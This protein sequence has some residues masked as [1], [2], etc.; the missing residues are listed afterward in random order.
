MQQH[1]AVEWLHEYGRRYP[2]AWSFYATWLAKPPLQWPDW[3]WCPMAAAVDVWVLHN[4]GRKLDHDEVGPIAALAAWRATQGIYRLHPTLLAELL[5]TP[6]TGE[7]PA[8]T[9]CR[10]PEFLRLVDA[11]NFATRTNSDT[12]CRD[13]R[14]PLGTFPS[15]TSW[16]ASPASAGVGTRTKFYAPKSTSVSLARSSFTRPNSTTLATQ[17]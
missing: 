14:A 7:V 12:W 17:D 4:Y 13:M 2:K 9:L 15:C 10:L 3:C 16:S 8:D 11:R 1:P 5:D 6:I